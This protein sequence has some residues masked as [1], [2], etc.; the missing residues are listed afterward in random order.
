MIQF[1]KNAS[2]IV[3]L[4]TVIFIFIFL[5]CIFIDIKQKYVGVQTVQLGEQCQL[6]HD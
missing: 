5:E 3:P 4:A 1:A 6:I 2:E